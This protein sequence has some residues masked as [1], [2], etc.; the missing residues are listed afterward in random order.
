V[1][2]TTE[3]VG[4]RIADHLADGTNGFGGKQ[5]WDWFRDATGRTI[6]YIGLDATGVRQPG[7]H[8]GAA[9]GRMAYVGMIFNPLPDPARGSPS[10]AKPGEGMRARYISGL[11]PL[12]EMGPLLRRQGAQVGPD[13]A[14]VWV[15]ISDGGAGLEDFLERHFPRVDAVILDFYHASEYVAKLAKGLHPTDEGAALAQTE[16]WCRLLRDAG[17]HTLIGVLEA[18]EWPSTRGLAAVRSEVLVYLRNQVQR[19]D[20][21]AYEGNGWYIG[22]GAVE[23][24]CKTVVGQRRKGSGMRWSEAGA[25]AVCHVRALDRS[26]SSQWDDFWRRSLAA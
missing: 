6:G 19:M 7:E 3:A 18:W 26:E 4:Q 11:Y 25:H 16:E 20:Y 24:A 2:R 21:P 15:A 9:E 13:N 23:S 22:S 12:A 14:E 10:I 1:Q 17:G 8:A 5:P